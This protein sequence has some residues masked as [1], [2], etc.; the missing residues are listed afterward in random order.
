MRTM[1]HRAALAPL[2][3]LTSLPTQA[4]TWVLDSE[5]SRVIFKYSYS[6]TPYQAYFDNIEGVVEIDPT[7]PGTCDFAVTIHIADIEIDDQETLSYLLDVDM[8]DVAQY[9]TAT[10]EADSCSLQSMNS[11]VADGNL[12][13]RNQTQ[14]MS[15]PFDLE[16]DT[17][18][19]QARFHLT[20]E[21][22]IQR[23]EYGVGQG[24]LANTADIP[25]D[26][27]IEVDVYA[28]MQE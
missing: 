28:V 27:D 8:F 18:G 7:N 2:L 20:S 10:F 26:V 15:F 25:N 12:T 21:V 22:T 13:I 9:P 17:S 3:L 5:D 16:V 24:Y 4:A 11:F 6:G 23:L 19:D 1:F 14:P